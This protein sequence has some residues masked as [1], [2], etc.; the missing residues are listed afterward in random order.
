MRLG[1]FDKYFGEQGLPVGIHE[2]LER[3]HRFLKNFLKGFLNH[4]MNK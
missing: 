2:S 3:F 4:S 1:E